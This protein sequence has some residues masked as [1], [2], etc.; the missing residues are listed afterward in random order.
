M[1]KHV[2]LDDEE[3][4]TP[5]TTRF[6]RSDEEGTTPTTTRFLRSNTFTADRTSTATF[7]FRVG[8]LDPAHSELA[9]TSP[10]YLPGTTL[11]FR[12]GALH[13]AIYVDGVRY[14]GRAGDLTPAK[15]LGEDA[16][17]SRL[18]LGISQYSL[19]SLWGG[20]LNGAFSEFEVLQDPSAKGARAE[21][22]E[23]GSELFEELSYTYDR[24]ALGLDLSLTGVSAVRAPS[25]GFTFVGSYT[26][27][28][29]G[30][31]GLSFNEEEFARFWTFVKRLRY[32]EEHMGKG[33]YA[34]KPGAAAQREEQRRRRK[35]Q[36]AEGGGLFGLGA[37]PSMLPEERVLDEFARRYRMEEEY[38]YL[39]GSFSGWSLPQP[40]VVHGPHAIR[41]GFPSPWFNLGGAISVATYDGVSVTI[42]RQSNALGGGGVRLPDHAVDFFAILFIDGAQQYQRSFASTELS[43]GMV[44]EVRAV[45][46]GTAL[47]DT[48]LLYEMG[49][50]WR[51]E[52]VFEPDHAARLVQFLTSA[53]M[54]KL[55]ID[56]LLDVDGWDVYQ[57]LAGL[58]GASKL[59]NWV[60]AALCASVQ[61]IAPLLLLSQASAFQVLSQTALMTHLGFHQRAFDEMGG[62][63]KEEGAL[64]D[65][66]TLPV[67]RIIFALYGAAYEY[68]KL[69]ESDGDS[70]LT[71][72]LA[73][74]P[75]YSTA[76]LA[77]GYVLNL[78]ARVLVAICMVVLIG[79]SE[80][81]SD[82]ILNAL[83][84]FFILTLDNELAVSSF[85]AELR[86]ARLLPRPTAPA[87]SAHLAQPSA[88]RCTHATTRARLSP[89][90]LSTSVRCAQAEEAAFAKMRTSTV[91]N[92]MDVKEVEVAPSRRI[93]RRDNDPLAGYPHAVTRFIADTPRIVSFANILILVGGSIIWAADAQKEHMYHV[94]HP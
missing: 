76:I 52:R 87:A 82:I 31:D 58:H 86:Q 49:L 83:A 70:K 19:D 79:E 30:A 43:S 68:R 61:L 44:D 67:L 59:K 24:E 72:F 11:N 64:E 73:A 46:I 27:T 90:P 9:V 77:V 32:L 5:T 33:P 35:Q 60:L 91:R 56:E 21:Q 63:E 92:Y 47:R 38:S 93:S 14:G 54:H 17:I 22:V 25:S 48:E 1:S 75:S 42:V 51:R 84:L 71:C 4:T 2:R 13:D 41:S 36:A 15:V 18:T 88:L 81:A 45:A 7:T 85:K 16:C 40:P 3:G 80:T 39:V 20:G 69:N 12:A 89:R 28:L 26:F 74:L 8:H 34:P 29:S 6:L 94:G 62:G 57:I 65:R 78:T 66:L 55:A 23:C 50:A 53:G 10:L 37:A